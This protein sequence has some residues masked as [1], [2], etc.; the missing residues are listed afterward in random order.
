MVEYHD[1]E[2][3]VPVHDERTQFE[4]LVL[5]SAQAGLS[6]Y[7]VLRKREAYRR[8]FAGFDP[9]AVAR[10]TQADVERL[11]GDVGLI[12]NRAK[13]EAAVGN[14][15]CFLEIQAQHGG[16]AD[17]LWRFVDG[18]QVVNHWRVPSEVPATTPLSDRLAREMKRRGFRFLGSTV[19]Y[20]HLQATGLVNDHL[21]SCFRHGEVAA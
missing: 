5:E 11:L 16:F 18:K 2:W 20:A 12:R 4:F 17:F 14:A 7:T 19:L 10:Y 15:R 13:I 3:G 6:W 21:V 9:V 1:R 8:A